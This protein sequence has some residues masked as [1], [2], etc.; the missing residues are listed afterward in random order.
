[1]GWERQRAL[2]YINGSDLSKKMINGSDVR[3]ALSCHFFQYAFIIS[4]DYAR[5]FHQ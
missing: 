5:A 3:I 1:M 2:K 4:K